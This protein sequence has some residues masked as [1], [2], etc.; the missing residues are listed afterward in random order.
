VLTAVGSNGVSHVR[1]DIVCSALVLRIVQVTVEF[2]GLGDSCTV[3]GLAESIF[4]G[5]AL[6]LPEGNGDVEEL[7]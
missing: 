5:V 3:G 6:R 1:E 2:S 7:W 4:E